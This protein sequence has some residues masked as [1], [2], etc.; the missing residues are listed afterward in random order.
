VIEKN[1]YTLDEAFQ[2]TG[3]TAEE[4]LHKAISGEIKLSALADNWNIVSYQRLPEDMQENERNEYYNLGQS[5]FSKSL[6]LTMNELIPLDRKGKFTPTTIGCLGDDFYDEVIDDIEVLLSE[7]IIT[8]EELLKLP[9]NRNQEQVAV[10]LTYPPNLPNSKV[11]ALL[12][13]YEEFWRPYFKDQT[14][15]APKSD[16]ITDWLKDTHGINKTEAGRIDKILRPDG[17][18][19]RK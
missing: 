1:W 11:T 13:A 2:Q 5:I 10:P 16:A 7:I 9:N 18:T 17:F 14:S 8:S 12:A 19:A 3:F 15:H 6:G 4:L